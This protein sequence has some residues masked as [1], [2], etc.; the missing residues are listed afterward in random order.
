MG[1]GMVVRI[2]GAVVSS[3]VLSGG[4]EKQIEVWTLHGIVSF[5]GRGSDSGGNN[6]AGQR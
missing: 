5:E 3:Y 4:G 6:D 2:E 1:N